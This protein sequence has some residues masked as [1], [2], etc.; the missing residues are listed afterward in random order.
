MD[1]VEGFAVVPPPPPLMAGLND[2][3]EGS[4]SR[5]GQDPATGCA[6]EMN[7]NSSAAAWCCARR[8]DLAPWMVEGIR[9]GAERFG[10][11]HCLVWDSEPNSNAPIKR[12][13]ELIPEDFSEGESLQKR[14]H[15]PLEVK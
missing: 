7:N 5:E 12:P 8:E 3:G 4:D 13:V 10:L 14:A 1:G 2:G 6:P 15:T 11:A 9:K